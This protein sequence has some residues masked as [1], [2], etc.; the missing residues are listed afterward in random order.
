MRRLTLS[1]AETRRLH[2]SEN[3]CSPSRFLREL[4]GEL[5][6]EIRPQIH[7]NRP[8]QGFGPRRGGYPR[9]EAGWG[10]GASLRNNSVG[11]LRLG[12]RVRHQTFGEG[13]VLQFE[14]DGDRARIQVKFEDA[15]SKW[16]VMGYARLQP[17]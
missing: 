12:Q 5:M 7:V 8:M 1:H 10:D 2:G 9:Q 17:L 16:L 13:V 15:G 4:P 11:G 14:G 6:Q 3:L